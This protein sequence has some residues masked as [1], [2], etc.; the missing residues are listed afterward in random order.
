MSDLDAL[1]DTEAEHT[2][3]HR[4]EPATPGTKVTKPGQARSTVYSVRL[5]PDEVAA[6]Q[7]L[8]DEAG[9][10]PST[11]VRSWILERLST[12]GTPV[13]LRLRQLVRDEVR[14]EIA[15]RV[16]DAVRDTLADWRREDARASGLPVD[17]EEQRSKRA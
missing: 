11:L 8:A 1:L 6:L 12:G 9:L 17:P 5:N 10:P 3:Q 4:D 7:V 13:G 14:S 16:R 15:T 2:E